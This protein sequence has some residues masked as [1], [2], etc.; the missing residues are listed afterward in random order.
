TDSVNSV[1]FSPDGKTIVSTSEDDT[2]RLW[3]AHTGEHIRTTQSEY[4]D[5]VHSVTFSPDGQIIASGGMNREAP[6][7]LWNAHTG[8]QLLTLLGRTKWVD[9]VVFSPDGK[10]I[11]SAS[12]DNDIHLCDVDTGA[13][14]RTLSGHTGPV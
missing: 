8:E 12:W 14:I 10:T 9:S 6:L 11:A 3:N 5:S 1:S 7:C 13:Y 2:I 4:T